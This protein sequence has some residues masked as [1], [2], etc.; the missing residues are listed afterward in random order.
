MNKKNL[1]RMIALIVIIA[2]IIGIGVLT[3]D[4]NNNASINGDNNY[5]NDNINHNEESNGNDDTNITLIRIDASGEGYWAYGSNNPYYR[6]EVDGV[7]KNLPSDLQGYNL[8]ANF[9]DEN[10]KFVHEGG[11]DIEDIAKDSANNEI[12]E[13][14][15]FGVYNTMYNISYI[16]III[17]NP[18]GEIVFNQTIEFDM[19]KMDLS[20]LDHKPSNTTN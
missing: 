1:K 11:L 3:S 12:T 5:D 9:Y 20:S 17:D 18:N 8:K 15:G 2:I 10:G 4:N 14:A 19:D 13:I 6:Y 7:F 16:E